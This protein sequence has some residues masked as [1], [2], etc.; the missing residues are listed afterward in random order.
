MELQANDQVIIVVPIDNPRAEGEEVHVNRANLKA[1]LKNRLMNAEFNKCSGL[2][3]EERDKIFDN[4]IRQQHV[5]QR[6]GE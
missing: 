2:T 4:T 6:N 3:N 5:V 1:R